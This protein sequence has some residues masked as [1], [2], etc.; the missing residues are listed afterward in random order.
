MFLEKAQRVL[1]GMHTLETISAQGRLDGGRH[2][3]VAD[4]S[5]EGAACTS[6][7]VYHDVYP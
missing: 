1:R 6:R 7:H 5:G 3:K 4:V 2:G